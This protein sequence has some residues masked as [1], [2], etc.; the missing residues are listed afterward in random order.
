MDNGLEGLGNA[1]FPEMT[2]DHGRQMLE[3]IR[4]FSQILRV[5]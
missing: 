3:R 1:K 5:L 4:Y 2:V